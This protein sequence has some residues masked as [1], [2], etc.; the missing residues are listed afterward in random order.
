MGFFNELSKDQI[1]SMDLFKNLKSNYFL[2]KLFN[3]LLKKKSL[4]IIKYNKAIKE[5]IKISIKDYKEY[6]EIYSPIEIEIKLVDDTFGKFI[7]INKGDEMYYHIYFNN[8][9]KDITRNY[10]NENENIKKVKII[11]DY[12]IKSF[13]GLFSNCKCIKY[14]YFKKFNRNN[15]NNMIGMFIGCSSLNELYLSNF[16]TNNVTR[17]DYMFY[18]CSSLKE[19]NLSNFN[20]NNV[21]NTAGM[22]C[23]C[24]SLKEL[25]LSNFNTNNVINTAGIFYRCSSLK[26]LN[27]SNFNTNNVTNMEYMFSECSSL[28]DLNLSNF[29]TNNVTN[30]EC[31]LNVLH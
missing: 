21:N 12:Q 13:E 25:N 20:S 23:G 26:E 28:K 4:N 18:G 8:N 19:L 30:M 10:L 16:N 31:S 15:I 3:I 14:I 22:V 2:Q 9:K 29:N 24:S 7:N 11:I 6:L 5:R 17:M 27:L 1:K